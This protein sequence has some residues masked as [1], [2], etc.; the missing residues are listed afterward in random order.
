VAFEHPDA[1]SEGV[2]V[3]RGT[4]PI[5]DV[6]S[7]LFVDI[8]DATELWDRYPDAMQLAVREQRDL[9][10]HVVADRAGRVVAVFGDGVCAVFMD[11]V[12]AVHAA[13]DV[14]RALKARNFTGVG[15]LSARVGVATGRCRF[16]PDEI[17][18]RPVTI[19]TGLQMAAHG[20][21]VL[22]CDDTARRC[23]QGLEAGAELTDL[24]RHQVPGVREELGVQALS[25]GDSAPP[26]RFLRESPLLYVDL[27][28]ETTP[29]IGR[30]RL[31]LDAMSAVRD[32]R[33]V[34]L[35]GPGGVGK[36]RV[37]QRV[38]RRVRRPFHDG[39]LHVDLSALRHAADVADVV[40]AAFPG[41][42]EANESSL[43]ALLR[44]LTPMRLLVVLENCEHVLDAVR[45]LVMPLLAHCPWVHVLTTSRQALGL[46]D[47]RRI[48]L[49]PLDVPAPDTPLDELG[50]NAAVVLFVAYAR[51]VNPEFAL[52]SD[53]APLVGELCRR[54]GGLPLAL[55]LA[56]ARLDVD[57]L[58]VLA[59]PEPASAVVGGDLEAGAD[60]RT[61]T[62]AGSLWWSYGL[63]TDDDQALF[64]ALGVFAGA[65]TRDAA[66]AVFG[67][68]RGRPTEEAIDRLV[69]CALVDRDPS[70]ERRLRLLEP[71]REFAR[72][73]L[74][75]EAHAG[76]RQRRADVMLRRAEELGPRV[77]GADEASACAELRAEFFDHRQAMAWFLD[78]GEVEKAARLVVALFQFCH[79]QLLGEVYEWAAQ[80]AQLLDDEAELA[81]EV[82]GAAALGA[83][84]AGDAERA[85]SLGERALGAGIRSPGRSQFWALLALV[86]AHAY[87]GTMRAGARHFRDLVEAG[88][89]SDDLFWQINSIGYEAVGLS[90]FGREIEARARADEAVGLA[91]RLGNP[92]CMH[93]ALYSLGRAIRTSEPEAASEAFAQ[94]MA[95]T[96][97]TGSNWNR[98]LDLI[99]WVELR[100]RLGDLAGATYGA[101]EL[102]TLLVGSGNR[103]QLSQTFREAACLLTVAGEIE[104]AVTI[105]LARSRLPAMPAGIDQSAADDEVLASLEAAARNAAP[106]IKVRAQSIADHD[107]IV[108]C[109][110]GLEAIAR[111]A[112]HLEPSVA[113]RRYADDVILYT[114]LVESTQLNVSVGDERFL[115][116]LRE[117]N[118][119]VR[120]RL[121]AFGGVEF[122][123]TGDGVGSHFASVDE[124]LGFALGLQAAFDDANRIHPDTPLMV[125]I[126]LCCGDAL[127]DEGN[128]F[129][130]AVVRAVR[131]CATA[132]PGQ[133]LVD[134]D[135]ASIAGPSVAWCAPMGSFP[136]KGFGTSVPLYEARLPSTVA[137]A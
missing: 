121:A 27:P 20:G 118:A 136:L 4:A 32:E 63:L 112:R 86:D 88:R 100:R 42:A 135:V 13:I 120:R 124:A 113:V 49:P 123:Y 45:T 114:D 10:S 99:E 80:I 33:L 103:S 67:A 101:L 65:F 58:E 50:R 53:N 60:A 95:A 104:L 133:V 129:G 18:G 128:L 74:S 46:P 30:D 6:Y 64:S 35:W 109:R 105:F 119:I 43:T 17:Y 96:R 26:S 77:R 37:A 130:Q 54:T 83:W 28:H 72:A 31:V 23:R 36:S 25:I 12:G 21:Q 34:T 61:A 115:H 78:E 9:V 40:L 70:D 7:V 44:M 48:P 71:V 57:P 68:S 87:V 89:R 134:Q 22:I 38:A 59:H 29:L 122:T 2:L 24:G 47:E 73:R 107:L 8:D 82:C 79:F 14:Q 91:S 16:G 110:S 98:S 137:A 3:D 41:L 132:G 117:H 84:F 102:L 125:R 116:L 39:V 93:W 19:A 76:L 127:E 111:D 92:D 66:T 97:L 55:E 15:Q 126:G 85:I 94:A 81:G 106:R 69:R 52:T 108:M 1:H 90:L 11:A 56:A 75:K 131:I 5:E 62:V 51:R